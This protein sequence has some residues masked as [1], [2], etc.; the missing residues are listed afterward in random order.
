MTTVQ[1][2]DNTASVPATTTA[3][4]DRVTGSQRAVNLIWE[5]TQMR[6]ALSVIWASLLVATVLALFGSWLGSPDI[7]LA[8]VVFVFGVANL[9]T[10]FYFGRTNH[11]RTGG[12]G[13]DSAGA[14]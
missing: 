14:R 12:I 8:A 5:S 6:I 11:Q 3:E 2:S 9:V 7:Q 13:G 4:Q 10:G 1:Q